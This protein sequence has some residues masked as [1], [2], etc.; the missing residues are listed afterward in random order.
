MTKS[1]TP[2]N[3]KIID[4]VRA[5]QAK[6]KSGGGKKKVV[7]VD[8]GGDDTFNEFTGYYNSKKQ[9]KIDEFKQKFLAADIAS[10][11]EMVNL[12]VKASGIKSI[13]D[14]LQTVIEKLSED[15]SNGKG[16]FYSE[17]RYNELLQIEGIDK[18]NINSIKN[19]I[20]E[21]KAK[22][23]I[24]NVDQPQEK[25]A[26]DSELTIPEQ[27]ASTASTDSK[28]TMP[29]QQASPDSK[30]TIPEPLEQ[31]H[32][33]K[34]KKILT[35]AVKFSNEPLFREVEQT[36][37]DSLL[38]ELKQI[39]NNNKET[40][41]TKFL[42]NIIML[43]DEEKANKISDYNEYFLILTLFLINDKS[44]I[45]ESIDSTNS[46]EP[47]KMSWFDYLEK[48]ANLFSER[49]E[50]KCNDVIQK[51]AIILGVGDITKND[52]NVKTCIADLDN[53]IKK[54]YG[55][56]GILT[57]YY[58]LD[59][60]DNEIKNNVQ[61]FLA[62]AKEAKKMEDER[63]A[64]EKKKEEERIA[65][66]KKDKLEKDKLEKEEEEKKKLEK[67]EEEKDKLEKEEE[68]KKKE[69]EE[70]KKEDE[71]DSTV[72]EDEGDS[73]KV[74]KE[75]RE[76]ERTAAEENDPMVEYSTKEAKK[77]EETNKVKLRLDKIISALLAD[78]TKVKKEA[79]QEVMEEIS[80]VGSEPSTTGGATTPSSD[81]IHIFYN[82]LST[83][84]TDIIG[85]E[86]DIKYTVFAL[87]LI[88]LMPDGNIKPNEFGQKLKN[89]FKN[90]FTKKI[91]HE[92]EKKKLRTLQYNIT[93]LLYLVPFEDDNEDL[94]KTLQNIK[95]AFD[96]RYKIENDKL[97]E[98]IEKTKLNEAGRT[99][100]KEE[101]FNKCDNKRNNYYNDD[102]NLYHDI[103]ALN[104]DNIQ[105]LTDINLLID[106][107]NRQ[108]I[109]N[110]YF[111]KFYNYF[112]D[113]DENDLSE[114]ESDEDRITRIANIKEIF[115]KYYIK[116]NHEKSIEAF[117]N[118][119]SKKSQYDNEEN[120]K[121]AY[122]IVNTG[123]I[124]KSFVA[125][126][127]ARI[128]SISEHFNSLI[129]KADDIVVKSKEIEEFETD[130]EVKSKE[131]EEKSK[132]IEV[133]SK[134][135]EE[136]TSEIE[137]F[138]TDIEQ[139]ETD[140]EQI[141]REIEAKTNENAGGVE[142]NDKVLLEAKQKELEDENEKLRK[143]QEKLRKEQK[144]LRKEQG[145]LDKGKTTL[146]DNKKTLEDNKKTLEDNKKTIDE[147]IRDIKQYALGIKIDDRISGVL[148]DENIANFKKG[149]IADEIKALYEEITEN[150]V[151][152]NKLF[153]RKNNHNATNGTKPSDDD[154]TDDTLKKYYKYLL[155]EKYIDKVEKS[156]LEDFIKI[157]HYEKGE[158]PW[159]WEIYEYTYIT[160][161]FQDVYAVNFIR[162]NKSND[163]NSVVAKLKDTIQG[164]VEEKEKYTFKTTILQRIEKYYEDTLYLHDIITFLAECDKRKEEAEYKNITLV[165]RKDLGH[166]LPHE[167]LS[168][169]LKLDD[170]SNLKNIIAHNIKI[171]GIGNLPYTILDVGGV[172]LLKSASNPGNYKT[173]IDKYRQIKD[174][175]DKGLRDIYNKKLDNIQSIIE[176]KVSVFTIN[177]DDYHK[178]NSVEITNKDKLHS[179]HPSI[180]FNGI[181]FEDVNNNNATILLTGNKV[182]DK[183]KYPKKILQNFKNAIRWHKMADKF[184]N[185]PN[186]K[187]I[188]INENGYFEEG[189]REGYDD[190]PLNLLGI[191]SWWPYGSTPRRSEDNLSDSELIY[192][193][194]F[195][196]Q[197]IME[198]I[199]I[200][201]KTED[202]AAAVGSMEAN[203]T[204]I[205]ETEKQH[206]YYNAYR[207]ENANSNI[208]I[209][210][211]K[212]DVSGDLI[213][214]DKLIT[215]SYHL[216]SGWDNHLNIDQL[217]TC[218]Y[219]FSM[220]DNILEKFKKKSQDSKRNE[221]IK[222]TLD[223]PDKDVV[224]E[225]RWDEWFYSDEFIKAIYPIYKDDN[226]M[227]NVKHFEITQ[228]NLK[229]IINYTDSVKIK[230][231]TIIKSYTTYTIEVLLTKTKS[232]TTPVDIICSIYETPTAIQPRDEKLKNTEP[233]KNQ[234]LLGDVKTAV[235]TDS[236][237][238][239]L[240]PTKYIRKY[241]GI[242]NFLCKRD[243]KFLGIGDGNDAC[244]SN[245]EEQCTTVE[246]CEWYKG[247]TRRKCVNSNRIKTFGAEDGL[248]IVGKFRDEYECQE[249]TEF[250]TFKDD[251]GLKMFQSDYNFLYSGEDL[252]IIFNCGKV[253]DPSQLYEDEVHK[254][255][256][257]LY[258][259]IKDDEKIKDEN[260]IILCGHS[261]GSVVA[262]AF[263]LWLFKHKQKFFE[264]KCFLVGSGSF[265]WLPESDKDRFTKLNN[266]F[267]YHTCL[268]SE[269]SNMNGLDPFAKMPGGD[270]TKFS[271]YFPVLALEGDI[272]FEDNKGVFN[273]TGNLK[274]FT[275]EQELRYAGPLAAPHL[276]PWESYFNSLN[277]HFK[278]DDPAP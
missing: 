45:A 24:I 267:I 143:E 259:K 22:I 140:I 52:Y 247:R 240:S 163:E 55:D 104:F 214:V 265:R 139:F 138:E 67:E 101:F 208:V 83:D 134:E 198:Y 90:I 30:L 156:S 234:T 61:G 120:F 274:T 212:I 48:Y 16:L 164:A 1:K 79:V 197:K 184:Q 88:L 277:K 248:E 148:N 60:N 58:T 158:K 94:T 13:N 73:K 76:E 40:K 191:P 99:Y 47:Q 169:D 236:E 19:A 258:T 64:Q 227:H 196:F 100:L 142:E 165:E 147:H 185:D 249:T 69:E 32:I 122:E 273:A 28:L 18:G 132:E 151:D 181:K 261:M 276:H 278:F 229:I 46:N 238:L 91:T 230:K 246:N 39:H 199:H 183:Q 3:K 192:K 218:V 105:H 110:T 252:Y 27:Q 177:K 201:A 96:K 243:K 108:N 117:F 268:T 231:D 251:E 78:P 175:M 157:G 15:K 80:K 135:I 26:P 130:I 17:K 239:N 162:L 255:F 171:R 235:I 272:S 253:F 95:Q 204:E 270:K 51:F 244:E 194:M 85:S 14:G 116:D 59:N 226:M 103:A 264:K 167:I 9:A 275:N 57:N 37:K 137:Q 41:F 62:E 118:Y 179:L 111:E 115:Y 53:K 68:E 72:E 203:V 146:D 190:V 65:Q 49:K 271:L 205:M 211:N 63:I 84:I 125:D 4:R 166:Y 128:Y 97:L 170:A 223:D 256:E 186:G 77:E 188:A 2:K 75:E 123:G 144:E 8:G 121:K 168:G 43:Y 92:E 160:P 119:E 33:K 210:L 215:N 257:E 133:K 82:E 180:K 178:N 74:K 207:L 149:K 112:K 70:D 225:S 228:A 87:S 102:I 81:I 220:L 209:K 21:G 89:F 232:G 224:K 107:K 71:G 25:Q 109:Y 7:E 11:M 193:K 93:K 269:W 50:V 31:D 36:E 213:D 153:D 106:D 20:T 159:T 216:F 200:Q 12:K 237:T 182:K 187:V 66:E 35:K 245:N 202:D 23:S 152:M 10:F 44:L 263:G 173:I 172:P 6:K 141:K 233:R 114:K 124:L 189:E 56:L 161:K 242:E 174:H 254:K 98:I 154:L 176:K 262:C 219:S 127:G 241:T 86:H 150:H 206:D 113:K 34:L 260:K 266:V 54:H 217:R 250:H 136:K 38:E 129:E 155:Y 195:L 5:H 42:F 222:K 221:I 131:I 145:E 126:T 29:E